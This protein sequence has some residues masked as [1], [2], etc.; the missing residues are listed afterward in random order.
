MSVAA[1][2]EKV[3]LHT[4]SLP[5]LFFYFFIPNL[6][7]MLALS[8]YSTFDGIF[9]GKKLGEEALAAIGLC[10]PVFPVIIA[11]ELLF[12]LGAASIAS[13]FLGKGEEE[14]ARLM[15]SS[16]FYFAFFSSTFL[17]V[18]LFV[19]VEEIALALGASQSVLGYVVEY[20]RVIF[21]GSVIIVLQPLL[22]VFAINDKRP[23]L[24]MVAMIIGSASNI[25]LNYLFL[26][27]LEWGIFGSALAT[28]L[29]H[30]LGLGILLSHFIS[31][32]GKIYFIKRF[33]FNAVL[34]SA[35]NGIPQSIAELSVAFV[36]IM[37]NHTLKSLADTESTR[38]EY[39]AIYSIVMYIGV[40]YWTI[41]LSCAQ[42]V[43]PIA[44]YNYGAG[45]MQRVRGIYIFGALFATLLGIA[46]YGLFL[47][48]DTFMVGLFLK[49]ENILESTLIAARVYFVA[50]IFLGF[51]IVSAIFFQAIRAPKSSFI[52]TL[53]Y[54]LIFVLLLLFVLSHYYGVFGVWLSYPLAMICSSFVALGVVVWEWRYGV[55]AHKG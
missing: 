14:R 32:R 45:N 33:S 30:A 15:F 21:L 11:F 48:I 7:A 13:Y 29:G 35:K 2:N 23:I 24:A 6:C 31:K 41:L 49:Q 38:V 37:F 52:I 54:N 28:I 40:V 8:T 39:L 47:F 5:R 9:V 19:Y 42:G 22:D 17:S 50:Y 44:S 12:G 4:D 3:N 25:V 53:S 26:F 10:W 51:N 27:I 20:L 16:V 34:A 36:M 1:D 46:M 18:L 55:L 43:Q